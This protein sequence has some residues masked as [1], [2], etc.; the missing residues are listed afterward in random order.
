MDNTT[1]IGEYLE[2]CREML[3]ESS[4]EFMSLGS[5]DFRKAE[6]CFEL[7]KRVEVLRR[8][9][10]ETFSRNAQSLPDASD[11]P[12]NS[13]DS[14]NVAPR[15]RRGPKRNKQEY[16]KYVIRDG[17]LVKIGLRRDGRSLYEH[18]V[19]HN[20]MDRIL[21]RINAFVNTNEFTVPE[22]IESI[23]DIPDYQ[24]YVVVA[25]LK[26]QGVLG[27]VRK[28]VYRFK[29]PTQGNLSVSDLAVENS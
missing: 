22:I 20:N 26:E 24:T 15:I 12:L 13:V 11:E 19:D 10:L 29:S 5:G 14:T 1:Q 7:A 16:P 23:S 4:R 9:V 25:L 21:A 27:T 2:K 28:G 6:D 8:D 17:N 3:F 18:T